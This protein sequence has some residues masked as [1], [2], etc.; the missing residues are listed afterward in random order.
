M[1]VGH[2]HLDAVGLLIEHH[3]DDLSR[4]QRVD[5]EGRLIFRP[6]ND[7]D[8]LALKLAD[9]RLDAG[10]AHTDAGADRVD[11]RIARDDGDLGARAGIAGDRLHLDDAVV[12]LRH[13][14][15]EQLGHELR[16]RARQEDLRPAHLGAHVEQVGADAVAGAEGLARDHLVA[17][18]DALAAAEIDDDV[19]VL[20]ALDH[21]VEDLTDPVLVLV[22]LAGALGVAHLLDDDLL[23]R[24]RRDAAEI[25][26]RQGIGDHVADES[27]GVVAASLI[28]G[29]FTGV[30]LDLI[31]HEEVAG[32]AQRA[33]LRVD[34]GVNV[35]LGAVAGAGRLRDRLF[36]CLD[37]DLAIDHLLAGDRLG[38]LQE[39][40]PIG[41]DDSHGV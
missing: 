7:V 3:L 39:F 27:A 17:A 16:V 31:D 41:A 8:L 9:H 33:A 38:D 6:R 14:L 32:Q 29:D 1:V 34:L 4:L 10:A 2:H 13:F 25:E 20:D 15:A 23:G 5:D 26:R 21:A 19:A 35:G 12:D 37:D 18:D 40:E 30:V 11:R 22:V 36:H 24:L 28:E